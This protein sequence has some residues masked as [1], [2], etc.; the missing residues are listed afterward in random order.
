MHL[1]EHNVPGQLNS[2]VLDVDD[3]CTAFGAHRRCQVYGEPDGSAVTVTCDVDVP[4][5][6]HLPV[7]TMAQARR[8][9]NGERRVHDRGRLVFDREQTW[10]NTNNGHAMLDFVFTVTPKPV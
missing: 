1:L 3:E 7:P 5:L 9:A 2:R 10:T 6:R 4:H 8:C